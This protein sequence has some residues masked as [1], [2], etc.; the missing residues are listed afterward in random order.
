MLLLMIAIFSNINYN[1]CKIAI[2]SNTIHE[3]NPLENDNIKTKKIKYELF[4]FTI[5]IMSSNNEF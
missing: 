3:Q 5:L 1:M 2:K 4:I